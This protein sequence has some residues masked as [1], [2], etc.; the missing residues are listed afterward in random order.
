[1]DPSIRSK[2]E[3]AKQAWQPTLLCYQAGRLP[4][5][6]NLAE[7]PQ[8]LPADYREFVGLTDGAVCGCVTFLP[9]SELEKYRFMAS[10]IVDEPGVWFSFGSVL[11]DPLFLE[12]T[13]ASV[14]LRGQDDGSRFRYGSFAEFLDDW[15]FGPK[16]ES[17]VPGRVA[18]RDEWQQYL[19]S[20]G[21]LAA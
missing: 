10:T 4:D 7:L 17:I 3:R 5:G 14:L 19:V 15:V 8:Q 13:T 21:I 6:V 2:I 1:M 11:N 20:I 18:R 12:S 9:V 16:Y